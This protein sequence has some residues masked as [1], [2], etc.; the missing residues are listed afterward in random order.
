MRGLDANA[1]GGSP[2]VA[3]GDRQRGIRGPGPGRGVCLHSVRPQGDGAD[4]A[5]DRG[6]AARAQL[7]PPACPAGSGAGDR[8]RHPRDVS[9]SHRPRHPAGP[10]G[11]ADRP[12]QRPAAGRAHGTWTSR[13]PARRVNQSLA[14]LSRGAGSGCRRCSWARPGT[15]ADG[16]IQTVTGQVQTINRRL[17]VPRRGRGLG[18]PVRGALAGDRHAADERARRCV[19]R[20]SDAI[21]LPDGRARVAEANRGRACGPRPTTPSWPSSRPISTSSSP[22]GRLAIAREA[23]ANADVLADITSA[24]AKSGQGK[25]ADHRRAVTELRRRREADRGRRRA[26]SR[27]PRPTWSACSC[28]IS[29]ARCW[30][31]SSRRRRILALFPTTARSQDLIIRGAAEPPRAR[32]VAANCWRRPSS[33]SGRRKMRPFIPSVAL[34]SPGAGSAA[35]RPGSSA[36]SAPR[37]EIGASMF[38]EIQ[39]L[40]FPDLA[41]YRRAG[42][43][44]PDRPTST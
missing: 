9:C 2:R 7:E 26:S 3:R 17:A 42:G 1:V 22:P 19:L 16:Q 23:A 28:S 21:Y 32:P 14:D 34:T 15:G 4:G 20:I 40:G 6:R 24:Y 39:S 8:R 29:A 25:L 37:S 13:S 35:A 38:W 5:S 43:R 36:T 27:S 18:Q 44:T 10:Y 41:I 12:G 11:R 33:A 30:P 31:R